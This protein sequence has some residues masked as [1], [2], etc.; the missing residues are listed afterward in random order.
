MWLCDD[1]L[2]VL[3]F[4]IYPLLSVHFSVSLSESFVRGMAFLGAD[5]RRPKV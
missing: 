2:D 1:V 3:Q 5:E 4:S